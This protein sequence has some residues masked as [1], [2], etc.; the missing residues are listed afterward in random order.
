M[1]SEPHAGCILAKLD[2]QPD[3]YLRQLQAAALEDLGWQVSDVT[4]TVPAANIAALEEKSLLAAEQ[5]R[6]DVAEARRQWS[7]E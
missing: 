4:L 5:E 1:S 2:A 6:E 3:I 7:A